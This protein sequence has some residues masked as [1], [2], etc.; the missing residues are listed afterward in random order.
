MSTTTYLTQVRTLIEKDQIPTA[1]GKLKLLLQNSPQLNALLLQ[2]ARYNALVKQIINGLLSIEQINRAKEMIRKDLLDL[3]DEIEGQGEKTAIRQELAASIELL[4]SC[5]RRAQ[6][7]KI[8]NRF[9]IGF[10][11]LSVLVAGFLYLLRDRIWAGSFMLTVLVHGQGGLDDRILKDEGEVWLDFGMGRFVAKID[12]HGE[13]TFKEIPSFYLNRKAVI[14]LEHPQPYKVVS[15][16]SSYLL[17]GEQAI[18]LQ[19][20]LTNLDSVFGFVRDFD[21]EHMLDSVRVSSRDIETYTNAHGWYSLKFPPNAQQ[22]FVTIWV[23]KPG[24]R[25]DRIDSVAP[26]L[27]RELIITLHPQN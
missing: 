17:D 14:T 10:L 19:V 26:H 5:D 20:R 11:L 12:A 18:Y 25:I 13:A 1:V 7:F 27:N 9:G 23:E 22:K 8:L 21:T 2:S 24:Y 3:I 15:P 16:D 6:N 4:N